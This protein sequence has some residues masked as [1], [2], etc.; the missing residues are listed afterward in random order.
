LILVSRYHKGNRRVEYLVFW[1]CFV[2]EQETWEPWQNLKGIAEEAV[3]EF[4]K[5]NPRKPNKKGF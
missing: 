5:G 4:Q 2:S 3:K 1:K